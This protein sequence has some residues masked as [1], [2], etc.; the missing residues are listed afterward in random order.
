MSRLRAVLVA[1]VGVAFVAVGITIGLATRPTGSNGATGGVILLALV[2]LVVGLWKIRGTPDASGAGPAVPWADDD[3]FATPAPERTDREPP[4][5]SDGLARVVER[6]GRTAREAETVDDGLAVV[7]PVLRETLCDA[8][9]QGGRTRAD[10]RAAIDGGNWTDDRVAASVLSSDVE[11]PPRPF[12]DRLRAWLF[13]ER[14]VRRRTRRAMGAVAEAA[15]E[16]LP[17]VP[18]QTAPRSVPV[19]QPRLEELR[20]G[21]GG[22]LQRAVDPDAIARGPGP[23]RR[24]RGDG[25]T[26]SPGRGDGTADR[27]DDQEVSDA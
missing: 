2:A 14:V 11:P 22:E 16:A 5:S 3:R 27:R 20:R 17:S 9:V 18:G 6:A 13:P 23:S 7:R 21:A 26:G 10:V 8:L 19:L 15:D 4:L 25:T 24:H 1:I 12:R